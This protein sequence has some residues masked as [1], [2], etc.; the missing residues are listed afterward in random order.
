MLRQKKPPSCNYV[1]LKELQYLAQPPTVET[2]K[3]D[4][5]NDV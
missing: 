4:A 5:A 3:G 1:L 2:T